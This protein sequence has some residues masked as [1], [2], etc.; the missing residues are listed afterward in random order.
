MISEGLVRYLF[1]TRLSLN[2]LMAPAFSLLA[3]VRASRGAYT[4][5]GDYGVLA[6][7]L[8]LLRRIVRLVTDTVTIHA[9]A[10]SGG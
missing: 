4:V 3:D 1:A 2:P 5:S 7:A 6:S 9:R 10:L 8:A